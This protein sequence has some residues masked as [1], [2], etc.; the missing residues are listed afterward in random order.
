MGYFVLD[1]KCSQDFGVNLSGTGSWA[2]PQ[3]NIETAEV[4]GRN[5]SLITYVGSWKNVEIEYPAWIARRFADKWDAF[6]EWWNAHTDKYY[7]MTDSYHS[8]YYRMVR[9]VSPIEPT[10][11]TL[12]QSGSFDLV[13]NCK[14]QKFLQDGMVKRT[15]DSAGYAPY[16]YKLKNPTEFDAYPLIVAR[17]GEANSKIYFY[18]EDENEICQLTMKYTV[19]DRSYVGGI[20]TYDTEIRENTV[21]LQGVTYEANDA[22]SEKFN[23]SGYKQIILPAKQET[24]L[25]LWNC[26]IDIYPRWYRI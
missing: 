16:E 26:D 3:R 1:G 25:R 4:P 17:I 6:S 12:N 11:G 21:E 7:E 19:S 13:F 24:T 2:T 18:D 23:Y 15:L 9:T 5:G 14:P 22:I 8:E 10:V 20:M